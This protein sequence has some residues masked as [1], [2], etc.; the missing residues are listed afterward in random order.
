MCKKILL[1]LK[2]AIV[3]LLSNIGLTAQSQYE[4]SQGIQLQYHIKGHVN[5]KNRTVRAD[6]NCQ[7]INHT[8]D[9]I[10]HI[11]IEL[12]GNAFS[13]KQSEWVQDQIKDGDLSFYFKDTSGMGVIRRWAFHSEGKQLQYKSL[14]NTKE[15]IEVFLIHPLMPGHQVTLSTQFETKLPAFK[16]M[17]LSDGQALLLSEWYPQVAY[18][19]SKGWKPELFRGYGSTYSALGDFEISLSLPKDWVVFASG[20]GRMKQNIG[21]ETIDFGLQGY[22]SINLLL[23]TQQDNKSL[24]S[25]WPGVHVLSRQSADNPE[26]LQHAINPILLWYEYRTDKSTDPVQLLLLDGSLSKPIYYPGLLIYPSS[27]L[28]ENPN[29]AVTELMVY[30]E[31]AQYWQA[32]MAVSPHYRAAWIKQQLGLTHPHE[33]KEIPISRRWVNWVMGQF[34]SW[35]IESL[36]QETSTVSG[37]INT[38]ANRLHALIGSRNSTPLTGC[39]HSSELSST[40]ENITGINRL[41]QCL[42]LPKD[43]ML[44]AYLS[45]KVTE[46]PYWRKFSDSIS[47]HGGY[48]GIPIPVQGMKNGVVILDTMLPPGQRLANS[49]LVHLDIEELRIKSLDNLY[50]YNKESKRNLIYRVNEWHAKTI[51]R[52]GILT[53]YWDSNVRQTFIM[54]LVSYNQH[55][56]IM[57]GLAIHNTTLPHLSAWEYYI[58]PTYGFQSKGLGGM[59]A[60]SWTHIGDSQKV[61]I[62]SNLKSFHYRTAPLTSTAL[63]MIRWM[64]YIKWTIGDIRKQ[65][66]V[67]D[68]TLRSLHIWEQAFSSSAPN[69]KGPLSPIWIKEL[70]YIFAKHQVLTDMQWSISLEHQSYQLVQRPESYL[71]LSSEWRLRQ[72]YT[73][74]KHFW[75]RIFGGTFLYNTHQQLGFINAGGGR[76]NF[77]L[78]ANGA[79]DY[80]YDYHFIG[81][82]VNEGLGAQQV[83]LADGG[84]KTPF[85]RAFDEGVTN[86]YLVAINLLADLPQLPEWLPVRPYGDAGYTASFANRT[87]QGPFDPNIFWSFGLELTLIKNLIQV[88][89]PILSSENINRFHAERGNYW[90]RISFSWQLGLQSPA[91]FSQR[92]PLF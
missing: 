35:E 23:Y 60:I 44:E 62:G 81:R 84:F 21:K 50:R 1:I 76:G 34:N 9:T 71:R 80:R 58:S 53:D 48:Q 28:H 87:A 24:R 77:S 72:M 90:R 86:R 32:W 41:E 92:S 39:M 69:F 16:Q 43:A 30:L 27:R 19:G 3:F 29:K 75:I 26:L 70:T 89:F 79:W 25:P 66:I 7:I 38:A 12:L 88:Y 33:S 59:G 13:N 36:F 55:D 5:P 85:T 91:Q 10:H 52:I 67:H 57:A 74:D 42:Q 45:G 6:W 40:I 68:L 22:P 63:R 51:Q 83:A 4:E 37:Q 14:N 82:N 47:I 31:Q 18:Y 46:Y 15:L 11:L 65:P 54:P 8:G 73:P 49:D 64:P 2:V 20:V 78:F 61:T 17:M 56:G